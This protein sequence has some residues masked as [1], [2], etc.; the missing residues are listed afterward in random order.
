LVKENY[1]AILFIPKVND[2]K[3]LETKVQFIS[4][5]SPS[6]SFLEKT[7]SVIATKITKLNYEKAKIDTLAIKKRRLKLIFQFQNQVEKPL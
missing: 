7:E 3:A 2:T 6:S 5:E 4:N 1:T